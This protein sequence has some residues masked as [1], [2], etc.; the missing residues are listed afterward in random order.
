VVVIPV[1]VVPSPKF[2]FIPYGA[3]PPVVVAVNDTS[4]F[5]TGLAGR[6]LKLVESG[7]GTETV[8]VLELVAVLAGED[9]SV[10]FSVTVND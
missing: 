6:K 3:V 9:E 1:P 7:G 10:A 8:M 5:T 2:Q 4:V